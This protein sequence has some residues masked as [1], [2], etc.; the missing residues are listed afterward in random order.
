[1]NTEYRIRVEREE[2]PSESLNPEEVDKRQI[3]DVRVA[4]LDLTQL[5]EFLVE[6]EKT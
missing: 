2:V 5:L 1:M 4:K 3:L 6:Q